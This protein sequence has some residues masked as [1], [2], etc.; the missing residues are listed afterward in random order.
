MSEKILF[1]PAKILR[2]SSTLR[3]FVL[4]SFHKLCSSCPNFR[5]NAHS[6]RLDAFFNWKVL[7]YFLFLHRTSIMLKYL[8]EAPRLGTQEVGLCGEIRKYFVATPSY[9]ELWI[10]YCSDCRPQWLS[11][12][13]IR[14]EIR[15]W[16]VWSLQCLATFFCGRLIMNYFLQSFSP[17]GWFKKGSYQFLMKESSQVL[18]NHLED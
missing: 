2:I 6:S 11:Q 14:L 17:F 3:P 18:V 4:K 10:Q 13:R 7:I 5:V 16:Q 1:G 9:L 15:M 12:M 8:L